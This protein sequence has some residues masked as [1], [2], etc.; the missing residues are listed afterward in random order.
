MYCFFVVNQKLG[1]ALCKLLSSGL[2]PLLADQE[3]KF[4][5]VDMASRFEQLPHFVCDE[6]ADFLLDTKLATLVSKTCTKNFEPTFR[7]S[8]LFLVSNQAPPAELKKDANYNHIGFSFE[9]EFLPEVWALGRR[10]RSLE[11]TSHLTAAI[12]ALSLVDLVLFTVTRLSLHAV[13]ADMGKLAE[14]LPNVTHISFTPTYGARSV[15]FRQ[16]ANL[17]CFSVAPFWSWTHSTDNKWLID[18]PSSVTDLEF[19]PS[20]EFPNF[21]STRVQTLKIA[22]QP[23]EIGWATKL[24]PAGWPSLTALST[25]VPLR[26]TSQATW[27]LK[28]LDFSFIS[29]ADLEEIPQSTVESFAVTVQELSLRSFLPKFPR[30]EALH[31]T[32]F[33]EALFA[34]LSWP[35]TLRSALRTLRLTLSTPVGDFDS[36]TFAQLASL[37]HFYIEPFIDDVHVGLAMTKID[38]D[39]LQTLQKLR[40]LRLTQVEIFWRIAKFPQ[41]QDLALCD[42]QGF[43]WAPQDRFRDTENLRRLKVDG[44]LTDAFRAQLG[45]FQRL[46]CFETANVPRR[47]RLELFQLVPPSCC[48]RFL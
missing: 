10:T 45:R 36:R 11:F 17:R 9:A 3:F 12:D 38:V 46:E 30:L 1:P 19:H 29:D 6:L 14:L 27:H 20:M 31:V 34:N 22:S 16:F 7:K 8:S 23:H 42:V 26:G 2:K 43:D 40:T 13:V 28:R 33:G 48:V 32:A 25:N 35:L 24:L 39:V 44:A 15:D 47:D 21:D 4:C 41:L 5:S 37:E 18:L